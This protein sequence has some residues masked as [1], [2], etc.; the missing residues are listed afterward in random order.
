MTTEKW[1]V[2]VSK[3]FHLFKKWGHEN[4]IG[5]QVSQLQHSQQVMGFLEIESAL[6]PPGPGCL[7]FK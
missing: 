1:E 5:E 6:A 4:Y 7:E 3:I 2:A